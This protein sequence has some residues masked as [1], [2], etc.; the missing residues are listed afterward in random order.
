MNTFYKK[1]FRGGVL[2]GAMFLADGAVTLLCP[3]VKG[4][5]KGVVCLA[6]VTIFGAAADI[7]SKHALDVL[8]NSSN[9]LKGC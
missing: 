6:S 7:G 4:L 8:E 3:G 2:V 1:I 5:T 9:K